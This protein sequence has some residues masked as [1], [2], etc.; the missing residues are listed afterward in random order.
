MIRRTIGFILTIVAV[1]IAGYAIAWNQASLEAF[2]ASVG[3]LGGLVMAAIGL[4]ALFLV[5]FWPSRWSRNVHRLVL[6]IAFLVLIFGGGEAFRQAF[7]QAP[8]VTF[9]VI[10]G[11][12]VGFWVLYALTILDRFALPQWLRRLMNENTTQQ[13]PRP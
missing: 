11:V 2:I 7:A 10:L 1:G 13:R 12:V 6:A 8:W 3:G 5:V 9:W 4:L